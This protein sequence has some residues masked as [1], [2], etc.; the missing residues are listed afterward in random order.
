MKITVLGSGSAFSGLTRF[1]SAYLVEDEKACFMID[2]G[3]DALRALQKSK[4]DM[5]SIQ[6]IFLT[7][8]HADHCGGLPAVLTAMHVLGRT[9]PINIHA[10]ST[11][12]DFVKLWLDNF[13]IYNARWSFRFELL[14][15]DVGK[16]SLPGNIELEF[17]R[18]KH[19]IKY[20]EPA[21]RAG[22]SPLSFS[23][24]VRE[25]KKS[26]FFSSDLGSI[27]EAGSYVGSSLAFIEAAH[28]ALAEISKISREAGDKVFFTHIPQELENDGAWRNELKSEFGIKDLNIVHDGQSFTI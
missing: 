3:S 25:G 6:D 10:P 15:L 17:V 8:L 12:L 28:P 18:T 4:V 26:F 9:M 16:K 13:F 7:H 19:L 11:Q 23:V 1:N 21:L 2:C 24:I 27:Q 14:P 5:F 22:I 20:E